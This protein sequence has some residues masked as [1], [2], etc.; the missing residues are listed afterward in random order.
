MHMPQVSM[1]R[2]AIVCLLAAAIGCSSQAEKMAD[3]RQSAQQFF[4]E[5]ETAFATKNYAAAEPKYSQA[6]TQGGLGPDAYDAA[7]VKRAICWGALNRAD[8][9]IA[10]LARLE[11]GASNLDAILAARS[12]VL[13]KQGKAVE[14]RTALAQAKRLN[15]AVQVLKD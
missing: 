13:N 3:V 2:M 15:P 6:I 1:E 11:P 5:A 9:A 7:A 10:E 12:Y 4:D 14:A 8:E